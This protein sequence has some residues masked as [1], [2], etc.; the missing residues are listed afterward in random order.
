MVEKRL[1][2]IALT[3]ALT[4][5]IM[6][7]AGDCVIWRAL[8]DAIATASVTACVHGHLAN[9]AVADHAGLHFFTFDLI[10]YFRALS[11][12]TALA[13]G[14]AGRDHCVICG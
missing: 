4:L 13:L 6:A 12:A 11:H 14:D 10:Y 3:I 5:L 1:I 7:G 9:R 2:S 8:G